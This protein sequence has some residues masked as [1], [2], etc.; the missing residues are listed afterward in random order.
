MSTETVREAETVDTGTATTPNTGSV[1][2][3]ELSIGA[4]CWTVAAVFAL[5]HTAVGPFASLTVVYGPVVATLYCVVAV[6]LGA[7]FFHSG[8]QLTP[9]VVDA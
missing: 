6:T 5:S 4:V 1:W 8:F 7:V 2:W 9:D 3:A